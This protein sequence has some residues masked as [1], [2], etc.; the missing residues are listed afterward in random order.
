[1]KKT[2]IVIIGGG[3]VGASVAYH[4]TMRGAKDVLILERGTAQGSGST[5]KATGGVRAQFET[6]INIKMSLYSLDFLVNCGFDCAYEPRGYLFFATDEKQFDYV[7]RNVEFQKK[8][9]VKDVE[10]VD[11][12]EIEK[13]C[14]ILNTEDIVGG[15]FGANDG[16]VNPLAIMRGFTEQAL[17]NGAKIQFETQVSAI[18][19]EGGKVVAVATN[20]GRIECEKV[21]IATGAWARE[22]A[23]TAGIDLPVSPQ[24]RQIVWA[25]S[26][27][28]LPE[29]L[30]MVIDIGSGFHFRPARDFVDHAA[31]SDNT[32]VLFAYPD[33]D[34]RESTDTDFD[35]SFIGRVYEKAKHRSPF[36]FD[37]KIIREKC[38]AGLYENTPDHH[39]ILGGCDVEG[40]YF[41]NGFSGHGVMHSPATGKALSEI[42]L[43]GKAS[44]LDVSCLSFDRFAKGELLH[45]TAFI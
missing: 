20:K 32:E 35:E 6:E 36:L 44:F 19:T 26:E 14:P 16:F 7:R 21:V 13:I 10:V 42:I 24:K 2:E 17:E 43:D 1:M 30:P 23:N 28:T 38:R 3:V 25:K 37:T 22:I 40:L 15:S 33:P 8:I 18:E 39:A 27:K 12:K 34:E 45:E 41:A 11:K 31:N 5:G 4:L 9:G 29:N